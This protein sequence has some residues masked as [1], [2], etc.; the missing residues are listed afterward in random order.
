MEKVILVGTIILITVSA[1]QANLIVNGGFE[2]GTPDPA[3]TRYDQRQDLEDFLSLK[4]RIGTQFLGK[5]TASRNFLT[6]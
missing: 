5:M 3:R 4:D 6:L 1:S 2:Q